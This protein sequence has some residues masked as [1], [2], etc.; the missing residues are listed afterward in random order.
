MIKHLL[1]STSLL[2]TAS[3]SNADFMPTNMLFV[4]DTGLE[5]NITKNAFNSVIDQAEAYYAPLFKSKFRATLKIV[6]NWDN[7]TVNASAYQSGY[8]WY[9][10]MYGGL[11]RRPEVT[12]DGFAAVVCHELGHHVAGYPYTGSTSWASNEG[13]SDYF[14]GL[15]CMRSLW[16]NQDNS[17]YAA[18]APRVVKEACDTAWDSDKEQNLCYR[19]ALAGKSISTLLGALGGTKVSFDLPDTRRV[20]RTDNAHPRAQ[21]RLD[22]YLASAVCRAEFNGSVIP[23][24]LLGNGTL[25]ERASAP[26]TCQTSGEYDQGYRPGCWFKSLTK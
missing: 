1:L 24:K 21:C 18:L 8:N 17:S 11:A 4:D 13:Q 22:T 15:S 23:G 10:N 12:A 14:A 2:V 19:V 9:V 25:A 7:S 20:T 3:E 5:A 26:Y 16:K 6:R